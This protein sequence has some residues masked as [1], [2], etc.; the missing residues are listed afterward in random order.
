MCFSATNG[1]DSFQESNS[2]DDDF[3]LES[4]PFNTS[5]LSE[6]NKLLVN[7]LYSVKDSRV[8]FQKEWQEKH[9][10]IKLLNKKVVLLESRIMKL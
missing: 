7:F 9:L 10:K 3:I 8:K 2:N 4:V 5:I 1:N 6:Q